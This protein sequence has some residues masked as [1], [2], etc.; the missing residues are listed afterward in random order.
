MEEAEPL[1]VRARDVV[2]TEDAVPWH[3]GL[4]LQVEDDA[5]VWGPGHHPFP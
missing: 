1:A 5:S 2:V 4:E 3:R